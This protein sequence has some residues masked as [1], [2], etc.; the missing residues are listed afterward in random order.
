[1]LKFW[2]QLLIS[3]RTIMMLATGEAGLDMQICLASR[4]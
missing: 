3:G 1:M 2:H 4:T